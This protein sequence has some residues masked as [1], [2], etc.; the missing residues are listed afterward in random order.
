MDIKLIFCSF[1]TLLFGCCSF[2]AAQNSN[3]TS[4]NPTDSLMQFLEQKINLEYG[5]DYNSTLAEV[6]STLKLNP[7]ELKKQLGLEYSNDKLD[8][9]RLRQLGVSVYSVMLA[10]EN[11][12]YGFNENSTLEQI[13]DLYSIPLKKL[14]A[15][16]K[17]DT[18]DRSLNNRS[19]LSLN[20]PLDE[21]RR[22]RIDFNH[23]I[24]KIGGSIVI[25]GMLVV[26]SSLLVTFIV[27]SQ[28][29]HI[30]L[31]D[32]GKPDL[33]INSRGIVISTDGTVLSDELVAVVTALQI[34][35]R[36]LE[37]RRRIALTFHR[38]NINFW[39]AA[40]LSDMPNRNY[41]CSKK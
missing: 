28:L 32:K 4:N 15:M 30:N 26:F 24:F 36:H 8:K 40:G 14:K 1:F 6:A 22:I 27:I 5:I 2:L 38:A 23:N 18:R 39:H 35:I 16:L 34:Y 10:R 33:K 31:A 3:N 9:M 29:R 17:L 25:V 20:I 21:I 7:I 11:L 41:D 19:L 13:S 37:E 12:M